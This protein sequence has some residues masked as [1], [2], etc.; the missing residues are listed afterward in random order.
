MGIKAD[1]DTSGKENISLLLGFTEFRS[2]PGCGLVTILTKLPGT[3]VTSACYST[4][5]F[6]SLSANFI[7]VT[8]LACRRDVITVRCILYGVIM[9]MLY[10]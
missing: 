2:C 1:L 8:Y 10:F 6:L 9:A 5:S 7:E 4:L 3:S